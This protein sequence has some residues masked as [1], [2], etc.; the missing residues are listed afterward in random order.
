MVVS[1]IAL[2]E[3]LMGKTQGKATDSL[4]HEKGSVTL[5]LQLGRKSPVTPPLDT[6]TDFP[7]ETLEVP[8]D[9]CRHWRGILRF[10]H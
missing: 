4:I 7:G 1:G 9:P 2:W 5:L 8:Q 6:R 10:G 3:S